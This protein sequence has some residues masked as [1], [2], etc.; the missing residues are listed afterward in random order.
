MMLI[1]DVCGGFGV[2]VE[3]VV[4]GGNASNAQLLNCVNSF[5]FFG[6]GVL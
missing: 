2:G 6:F 4:E 3:E 5:E 1:S